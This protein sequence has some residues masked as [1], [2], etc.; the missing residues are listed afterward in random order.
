MVERIEPLK[1]RT[2][3]LAFEKVA[4]FLL[5]HVDLRRSLRGERLQATILL[6]IAQQVKKLVGHDAPPYRSLLIDIIV[7]P[8][9]LHRLSLHL[10]DRLLKLF[11][12]LAL[13]P[14]IPMH[15]AEP[16]ADQIGRQRVINQRH[17]HVEHIS[18]QWQILAAPLR[19]RLQLPLLH[20]VQPAEGA[21]RVRMHVILSPY[22]KARPLPLMRLTDAY[23][24]YLFLLRLQLPSL[25]F[26]QHW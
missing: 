1:V 21:C 23:Q 22:L 9:S 18:I 11:L 6:G 4:Q 8:V 19:R 17:R 7:R 16:L 12:R 20:S 24:V 25:I 5:D 2:A 10:P 3:L 26:L 15:L 13:A 14:Q